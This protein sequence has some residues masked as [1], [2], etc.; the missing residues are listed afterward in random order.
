[1]DIKQKLEKL[2]LPQE[3]AESSFA[4]TITLIDEEEALKILDY[5]KYYGITLTKASELKYLTYNEMEI[6]SVLTRLQYLKNNGIPM[7]DENGN[8][9]SY[10]FDLSKKK[11]AFTILYPSADLSN[12]TPDVFRDKEELN[13]DILNTL[14]KNV[15]VGLTEDNY[16]KYIALERTLTLV[17]QALTGENVVSSEMS[18]NLIKLL[19]IDNGYSD[20]EIMYAVLVYNQ[21]RSAEEIEKIKS[22]IN[23]ITKP[24]NQGGSLAL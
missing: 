6:N 5:L 4:T 18:N 2:G 7:V 17:I 9:K 23:E 3:F 16:D 1:M 11:S 20:N 10:L 14:N 13:A 15:T 19:S 21:N 22:I 8:V 12:I 24:L